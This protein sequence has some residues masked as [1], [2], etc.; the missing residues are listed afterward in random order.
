MS[1]I[2][3]QRYLSPCGELIL[4]SL[5]G[6]LCLCDWVG[7]RHRHSTEL[8]LKRLLNAEYQEGSSNVIEVACR[9]LDE[10]F[11][12]ERRVFD[13]PLLFAGSSFQKMVWK[14]L[15]NIPYGT[16]ISYGE[17]S[18]R[19]GMPK[20]VRALANA[21]GANA[22]SVVVPCHRVVGSNGSLT[23][24]GGG[25]DVKRFLLNLE[26]LERNCGTAHEVNS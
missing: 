19:L 12:G 11:R 15:V 22:I 10:Y 14:E 17:M 16:T 3:I 4:G 18:R 25:L 20:A 7:G 2:T 9:Q 24:Y 1:I 23:G 6:C 26:N 21:N 5:D 8:R 13:L